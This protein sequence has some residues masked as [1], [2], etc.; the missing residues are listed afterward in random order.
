MSVS[1]PVARRSADGDDFT[2]LSPRPQRIQLPDSVV[3][4]LAV[5]PI[6]LERQKAI[7]SPGSPVVSSND[8][9]GSS[10]AADCS[11][12]SAESPRLPSPN[13]AHAGLA[14]LVIAAVQG[15]YRIKKSAAGTPSIM[16]S[17]RG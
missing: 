10:V 7:R 4:D 8:V 5:D 11:E 2:P 17:E 15:S 13:I 3:A 1:I 9:V 6:L 16:R 12:S 14:M